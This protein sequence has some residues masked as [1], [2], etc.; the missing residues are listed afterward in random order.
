METAIQWP[1]SIL[2]V[3]AAGTG[4]FLIPVQWNRNYGGWGD[5]R[6]F[7]FVL[8]GHTRTA[9]AIRFICGLILLC[10]AIVF[11]F[12]SFGRCLKC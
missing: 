4:Y 3:I 11:F 10:G 9:A 12:V 7:V 5:R 1:Y 6:W 8:N 2:G